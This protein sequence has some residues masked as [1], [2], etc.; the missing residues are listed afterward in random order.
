[1]TRSVPIDT[2]AGRLYAILTNVVHKEESL[3][4]GN[5][6]IT[7]LDV[8]AEALEVD[9][10]NLEVL[11]GL[12]KIFELVDST[13]ESIKR[14][15]NID[16]ELFLRPLEEIADAFLEVKPSM[17]V[18]ESGG[19]GID[20]K[21]LDKLKFCVYTLSKE[22]GE[23]LL[24]TEQLN[25]LLL[26]VRGFLDKVLDSDLDAEIK[27]FLIEKLRDME[28]AIFNYKFEGS[29]GLRKVLESTIGAAILN[30]DVKEQKENPLVTSFFT[31]VTRLAAILNIANTSK[32]LAPDVSNILSKLS[33]LLPGGE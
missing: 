1:M 25:E 30:T 33:K 2:P 28:Q 3:C 5:Q 14:L 11:R 8:L 9:K 24:N 7:T 26:E 32:Q 15:Q 29:E 22:Q 6:F 4:Q 31:I 23:I 21:T 16:T 18:R 12:A 13:K 10:N 17:L 19:I 27:R 20:K